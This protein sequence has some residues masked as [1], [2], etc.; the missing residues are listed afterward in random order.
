MQLGTD[1]RLDF[2]RGENLISR[3]VC[4]FRG[5]IWEGLSSLIKFLC[6]DT[7]IDLEV[8]NFDVAT[9]YFYLI[10]KWIK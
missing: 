1:I 3:Y 5:G 9:F 8:V 4:R 2:V 10:G 6:N 7:E